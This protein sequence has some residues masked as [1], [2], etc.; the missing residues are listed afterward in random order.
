MKQ[1]GTHGCNDS[2]D[3]IVV[4]S[5]VIAA[6]TVSHSPQS[7]LAKHNTRAAFQ[8]RKDKPKDAKGSARG[9]THN[10]NSPKNSPLNAGVMFA[11]AR[12]YG[13]LVFI[14][15]T[16]LDA[17]AP[18]TAAHSNDIISPELASGWPKCETH[19]DLGGQ[20]RREHLFC[21]AVLSTST[22]AA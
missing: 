22:N 2:E 16:S 12:R 20:Q 7:D 3:H 19:F 14:G 21:S 5:I 1:S 11:L 18:S 13:F 9:H 15:G 10:D 17:T 8:P 4:V 6:T